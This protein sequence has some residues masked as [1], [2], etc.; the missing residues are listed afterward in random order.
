MHNRHYSEPFKNL[1]KKNGHTNKKF[2]IQFGDRCKNN[3]SF[4]SWSFLDNI[5][6]DFSLVKIRRKY[7]KFPVILKCPNYKRHWSPLYKKY[8]DI[9]FSKKKN[10]LIWRGAAT[11]EIT[12]ASNRF[13]LVEKWGNY[14]NKEIDIGFSKL[15]NQYE[16]Q[17][18]NKYKKFV[19]GEKSIDEILQYKYIIS[20]EGNDKDSGLNWKLNSN[21][22]I[23]MCKPSLSSWLMEETLIPNYHYVE[24]KDDFTD[25]KEKL[26]WCINNQPKC[27]EIIKNANTFMKKF[28]N[29]EQENILENHIINLYFKKLVLKN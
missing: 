20:V 1:L 2:I 11:S 29:T 8:N 27:L 25:I 18:M 12:N 5:T 9:P 22:V 23:L 24:I 10:M 15:T 19:K 28:F 13:K 26:D 4:N 17:I 3:D 14:K 7:E 6:D 21:S 16:D